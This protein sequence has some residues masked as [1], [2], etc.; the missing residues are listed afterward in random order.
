[1]RDGRIRERVKGQ[2]REG[3][4]FLAANQQQQG[5]GGRA[6]SDGAGASV[7]Q[8]Q[9]VFSEHVIRALH[10]LA[11]GLFLY[12]IPPGHLRLLR[13]NKTLLLHCHHYSTHP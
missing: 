7:L 5:E 8:A 9:R 13:T 6:G 3:W 12:V 10:K 1:M 2:N 11:M 4:W